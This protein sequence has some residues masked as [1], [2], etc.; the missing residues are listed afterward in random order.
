ML[1]KYHDELMQPYKEAMAFFRKIELQL[2]AL[3]KGSLKLSQSGTLTFPHYHMFKGWHQSW[4]CS[5]FEVQMDAY[6]HT[7]AHGVPPHDCSWTSSTP[8]CPPANVGPGFLLAFAQPLSYMPN[9]TAFLLLPLAPTFLT[10]FFP[11]ILCGRMLFSIQ[12]RILQKK[13]LRAVRLMGERHCE[14]NH[15]F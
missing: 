6:M 14:D 8:M 3:S 2:N 15:S 12:T 4:H 9:R 7:L 1:Q 5:H 13:V 10:L 11:K